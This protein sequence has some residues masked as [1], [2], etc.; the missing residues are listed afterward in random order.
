MKKFTSLLMVVAF[1]T[2]LSCQKTVDLKPELEEPAIGDVGARVAIEPGF[3]TFPDWKT[4]QETLELMQRKSREQREAWEKERKFTSLN[5][6]YEYVVDE[7]LVAIEQE[8]ALLKANPALKKTLK[9]KRSALG[10]AHKSSITIGKEGVEKNVFSSAY[11]LL[12]NKD[13]MVKI[14]D[15]LVQLT[16][17]EAKTIKDEG[18]GSVN[19]LKTASMSMPEKGLYVNKIIGYTNAVGSKNAK[20]AAERRDDKYNSDGSLWLTTWSRGSKLC[21]QD[22]S[23]GSGTGYY[24]IAQLYLEMRF[25]RKTWYGEWVDHRSES[26]SVS[27]QWGQSTSEYGPPL[28]GHYGGVAYAPD[29]FQLFPYSAGA[30]GVRTANPTFTLWYGDLKNCYFGVP[31]FYTGTVH[32]FQFVDIRSTISY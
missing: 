5:T 16:K 13:G 32:N 29:L 7:E 15:V 2:A 25:L 18:D 10:L 31:S 23:G 28:E 22:L 6:L 9:H 26:Y 27:G 1:L 19:L 14:G 12:L 3:L 21:F 11:A 4:F 24:T 30:N 20:V 8:E 17:T